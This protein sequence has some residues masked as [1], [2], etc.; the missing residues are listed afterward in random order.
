M[1]IKGVGLPF[2][3]DLEKELL[4]SEC[5]EQLK[6]QIVKYIDSQEPYKSGLSGVMYRANLVYILENLGQELKILGEL[7]R[8]NNSI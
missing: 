6:E 7:R 5:P 2:S 1:A 8:V 3:K 4:N